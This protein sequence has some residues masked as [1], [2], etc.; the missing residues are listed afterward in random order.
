VKIAWLL[1]IALGGCNSL[2]D[3][4]STRSLDAAV[5]IDAQ[6]FDAPPDAPPACP[7][8]GGEPKFKAAYNQLT[9]VGN[10]VSFTPAFMWGKAVGVCNS[11]IQQGALEGPIETELGVVPAGY[12]QFPRLSQD[13]ALLFVENSMTLK[14]DIWAKNPD[15]TWTKK[16]N[17]IDDASYRYISQATTTS[18][19]HAIQTDFNGSNN[20]LRELVEQTSGDWAS[21]DLY[22]VSELGV[23]TVDQQSLSSD[24][25]H[26]TFVGTPAGSNKNT[27]WWSRRATLA[28]HFGTA[29]ELTTVPLSGGAP[30]MADDCS[31][32]YFSGLGAVFYQTQ[33]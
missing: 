25:L 12:T 15:D 17:T 14:I 31:R 6:Y 19:R 24:G 23:G 22:L 20:Q 16:I 7:A 1:A 5:P 21:V 30:F 10:C 9:G 33:L 32:Y 26:L 3:I 2:Y 28:D 27:V 8:V 4:T 11:R 29:V 13:G 18:P